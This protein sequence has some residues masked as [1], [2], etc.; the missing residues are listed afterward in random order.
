MTSGSLVNSVI[1]GRKQPEP[2]VGMEATVCHWSDR[3]PVEVAEVIRF[4][5][6]PRKG[7]VRGV[8]CRPM[9]AI[10]VSG[11]EADGSATYR[12]E[13]CP[14]AP[15]GGIYLRNERGQYQR[16]RG[17]AKLSLGRAECYYD[18]HF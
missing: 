10:L 12:Y 4:K 16:P 17:G 1:G 14:D 6:G 8:K 5:S 9:N 7:Q 2:T 3:S 15:A 11:S 13:R 18:P